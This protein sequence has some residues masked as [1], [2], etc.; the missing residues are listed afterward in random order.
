MP[1]YI[2]VFPAGFLESLDDFYILSSGLIL[3]QTTNSVYN[4]TLLKL[5]VP[6]SLLAWQ[7]VR[8]AN[9]MANGGREWAEIFSKYNSGKWPRRATFKH[10]HLFRFR[11][12]Q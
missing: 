5:V 2:F 12:S 8:V 4:K 9:M 11:V 7:R 10:V 3:L 1:I 6:Q